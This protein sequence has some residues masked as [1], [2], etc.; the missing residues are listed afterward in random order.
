MP[1][2]ASLCLSVGFRDCHLPLW[3]LACQV[4]GW[5]RNSERVGA[6]WHNHWEAFTRWKPE[7]HWSRGGRCPGE[8]V[9]IHKQTTHSI[10]FYR[11][12]SF[13]PPIVCCLFGMF[14]SIS[15][16]SFY[17]WMS[18][19]CDSCIKQRWKIALFFYFPPIASNQSPVC[20]SVIIIPTAA[21]TYKV[22][23]MTGDVYGAGTDANVFLTIYGNL[24]DTG[25]RK[26]SKSETNSNKF[27]RG[28]VRKHTFFGNLYFYYILLYY[29]KCQTKTI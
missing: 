12:Y 10:A 24:G 4:R 9:N 23:V 27:E 14:L 28:S 26:L 29:L 22:S 1:V 5:Q 20:F 15:F 7:S 11:I 21:H 17:P 25:E 6:L 18:L 13:C 2:S 8:Y 16:R 3:A 19:F